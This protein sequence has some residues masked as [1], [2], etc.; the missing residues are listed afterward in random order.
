MAWPSNGLFRV[1]MG[2]HTGRASERGGDYFGSAVNR[3]ARLMGVAHGGQIVC[4]RVT[5]D[6]AGADL[7]PGV[8]FVPVGELRLPDVLEPV[9]ACC[10]TAEGLETTCR[11]QRPPTERFMACPSNA[12]DSSAVML[13]W[14]A[15]PGWSVRIVWSR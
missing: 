8:V 7:A 6:L 2:L 15:S 9:A 4:S 10:V 14:R 1:R 13:M 11:Y 3:A 5:A 12:P